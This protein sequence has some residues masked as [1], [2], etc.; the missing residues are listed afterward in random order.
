MSVYPMCYDR[1]VL[2]TVTAFWERHEDLSITVAATVGDIF[3][4]PANT[5]NLCN[6]HEGQLLVPSELLHCRSILYGRFVQVQ[7]S[8][9]RFSNMNLAEI[10]VYGSII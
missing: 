1:F 8:L 9:T 7:N 2:V 3:Y 6:F 10:E 5:D 4:D